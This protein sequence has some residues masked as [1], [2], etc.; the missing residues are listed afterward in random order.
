MLQQ[1]P[2]LSSGSGKVGDLIATRNRSGFFLKAY[3]VPVQPDSEKQQAVYGFWA[4]IG[5]RWAG[6]TSEQRSGW[7]RYASHVPLRNALG[8]YRL[9]TGRNHFYRSNTLRYLTG[10][11]TFWCDDA[12]TIFSLTGNVVL[13]SIGAYVDDYGK[14]VIAGEGYVSEK[15]VSGT[16]PDYWVTFTS[17]P[18]LETKNY[19]RGPYKWRERSILP[20][21][22]N[23]FTFGFGDHPTQVWDTAGG[24]ACFLKGAV[25]RADGR[26]SNPSYL[27]LIT[28]AGWP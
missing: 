9:V 4:D 17:A 7:A 19:F 15:R 18:L 24:Q 22:T 5:T 16:T 26:C 1:S 3:A 12:P 2:I 27:K 25:T 10:E 28:I 20:H 21:L 6:L 13:N 11:E 23:T 14:L 8:H